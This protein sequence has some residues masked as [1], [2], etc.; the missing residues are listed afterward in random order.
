MG[1]IYIQYSSKKMKFDADEAVAY[2][3]LKYAGDD[4]FHWAYAIPREN[5]VGTEKDR[6][7]NYLLRAVLKA[8]HFEKEDESEQ[9]KND[10]AENFYFYFAKSNALVR[11]IPKDIFD[12]EGNDFFKKIDPDNIELLIPEKDLKLK[13]SSTEDLS[14]DKTKKFPVALFEWDQ[15]NV[16]SF[17]IKNAADKAV[18]KLDVK[19]Q[20][21]TPKSIEEKL[22]NLAG[23]PQLYFPEPEKTTFAFF[24]SGEHG[25]V[26]EVDKNPIAPSGVIANESGTAKPNI[27]NILH[28]RLRLPNTPLR[29]LSYD[30]EKKLQLEVDLIS[31][32]TFSPGGEIP[33]GTLIAHISAPGLSCRFTQSDK[34]PIE[35]FLRPERPCIEVEIQ[36]PM[37]HDFTTTVSPSLPLLEPAQRRIGDAVEQLNNLLRYRFELCL[38]DEDK[39]WEKMWEKLKAPFPNDLLRVLKNLLENFE[40]PLFEFKDPSVSHITQLFERMGQLRLCLREI[41]N[42]KEIELPKLGKIDFDF[43]LPETF[44]LPTLPSLALKEHL[45]TP[46]PDKFNFPV[47]KIFEDHCLPEISCMGWPK[48]SEIKKYDFSSLKIRMRPSVKLGKIESLDSP[49]LRIKLQNPWPKLKLPGMD[50]RTFVRPEVGDFL[51][52]LPPYNDKFEV[53]N[54]RIRGFDINEPS[55]FKLDKPIPPGIDYSKVQVIWWRPR[56]SFV[57]RMK[58]I[59]IKEW[60][61]IELAGPPNLPSLFPKLQ[62]LGWEPPIVD[63]FDDFEIPLTR[64]FLKQLLGELPP[65]QFNL[66]EP[67]IE[68]REIKLPTVKLEKIQPIT[69]PMELNLRFPKPNLDPPDF[70][71]LRLWLGIQIDL[72]TLALADK[73]IYFYFPQVERGGLSIQDT[74]NQGLFT[75]QAV[76]LDFITLSIPMRNRI[77]EPP[78]ERNHDGY[79]EISKRCLVI[80]L[81][82]GDDTPEPLPQLGAYFPGGVSDDAVAL[83]LDGIETAFEE[84]PPEDK[85]R[86]E[87]LRSELLRRFSLTLKSFSPAEWGEQS[88]QENLVLRLCADGITFNG[89]V[90]K[91]KVE[92]DTTGTTGN[93]EQKES[94]QGLIEPFQFDP[95]DKQGNLTSQVVIINN[96]IREAAVCAT[97]TCPG[98]KDLM[99]NIRVSLRQTERGKLPDV[100]ASAELEQSDK[101]PLAQCSIGMLDASL[102]TM[103]FE[104]SWLRSQGDWDYAAIADAT[105]GFSRA[106]SVIPDLKDL[107]KPSIK[108][109][110]LDLRRMNLKTMRVP[111]ALERTVRFNILNNLFGVELGDLEV[112]WDWDGKVPKP[113]ILACKLAKFSYLNPGSLEVHISAGAL[114]ID[115]S[116]QMPAIR[117]PSR[118]GIEVKLSDSAKFSGEVGWVDEKGERYLFASGSV[119]IEGLPET[120]ALLKIGTGE[121]KDGSRHINVVLFGGTEGL[122]T[123]LFTGAVVKGMGTGIGINNR[124]AAIPARPNAGDI[125]P[126]VESIKPGKIDSWS[127]V[128]DSGFYLSVIGSVTLASNQGADTTINAYVAKLIFSLDTNLDLVAAG[129]LWLSTSPKQALAHSDKPAAVG[130]MVLSPRDNKLEVKVESRPD[131]YV[132]DNDLLKKLLSKAKVRFT[133]R[134][135]PG[136]VDYYLEEVSYRDSLFGVDLSIEGSYRFAVFRN[137]VLLR[138]DIAAIGRLEKNLRTGPGG[139]DLLGDVRLAYGYAGLLT[140]KGA[141]AYA[142][143]DASMTFNV[144]AWIEIGFS[145]SFK[146]CGKRFHRSWSLTFK[147]QAPSLELTMRGNIGLVEQGNIGV[148]C[149]VGIDMAI[150]GYRLSGSAR[151]SHQPELYDDARN[152]IGAF[153]QQLDKPVGEAL[154]NNAQNLI[155]QK[156]QISS[157]ARL[158]RS[159]A[160]PVSLQGQQS[161][162]K[163]LHYLRSENSGKTFHLLL[164][165]S[166]EQWLTPRVARIENLRSSFG[167]TTITTTGHG[168]TCEDKGKVIQ[169]LGLRPSLTVS[170]KKKKIKSY[171]DLWR[172]YDVLDCNTFEITGLNRDVELPSCAY[173][174]DF[175]GGTWILHQKRVDEMLTQE[176]P[177]LLGDVQRV[178]VRLSEWCC[179]KVSSAK[180][181]TPSINLV[182]CGN[183]LAELEDKTVVRLILA[184]KN[185]E[186][187]DLGQKAGSNQVTTEDVTAK[188]TK[189]S[190]NTFTIELPVSSKARFAQEPETEIKVALAKEVMT[191]WNPA[192]RFA[193]LK[194]E[195]ITVEDYNELIQDGLSLVES[196]A[197]SNQKDA[198][199]YLPPRS[200]YLVRFSPQYTS[201]DKY[202]EMLDGQSRPD[203]VRT[204]RFRPLQELWGQAETGDIQEA[205]QYQKARD[206]LRHQQMATISD[207]EPGERLNERRAQ[208]AEIFIE[209]FNSPT[210]PHHF[211]ERYSDSEASS[212]SNICL[213][214]GFTLSKENV[215]D[216]YIRRTCGVAKKIERSSPDVVEGAPK[217]SGFV[218][219]LPIRQEFNIEK[220][221]EGAG[222]NEKAR[223][224]VKLPLRFADELLRGD[225]ERIGRLQ[226]F[227][228]I[229][230]HTSVLHR[231]YIRP[232]IGFLEQPEIVF[233]KA[234]EVFPKAEEQN[235]WAQGSGKSHKIVFDAESFNSKSIISV[236]S[237]KGLLC[238]VKG[239]E[240]ESLRMILGSKTI[241]DN[242]IQKIEIELT[243]QL[244]QAGSLEFQIL[245][246]GIIVPSP[247]VF[248]DEFQLLDRKT[249]DKELVE[250]GLEADKLKVHYSA[251]FVPHGDAGGK[252]NLDE[253]RSNG[254]VVDFEPVELFVPQQ[255]PFPKKLA[256]ALPVK[257]LLSPEKNGDEDISFQLLSTDQENPRFAQLGGRQIQENDFEIWVSDYPIEQNGFYV[258]SDPASGAER[259]VDNSSLTFDEVQREPEQ[260]SINS[261]KVRLGV[262]KVN[263]HF[264]IENGKCILKCGFSYRLFI[265]PTGSGS[266]LLTP[267]GKF[268]LRED[269]L[270]EEWDGS[271]RYRAV[272][273]LEQIPLEVVKLIKRGRI[274]PDQETV[275]RGEV[276][277]SDKISVDDFFMGGQNCLRTI[278]QS[279]NL[280]GGGVE[281]QYRD[282]DDS[283]VTAR[284]TCEIFK[285]ERY[286]ELRSDFSTP[287][288]W[289][290]NHLLRK[291]RVSAQP[292]DD[293]QNE[294]PLLKLEP[295]FLRKSGKY[296][297][298]LKEIQK[299]W[300]ELRNYCALPDKE[301]KHLEL[302][303]KTHN[304]VVVIFKYIKSPLNLHQPEVEAAIDSTLMLLRFLIIGLQPPEFKVEEIIDS[305]IKL[306]KTFSDLRKM[307]ID[308]EEEDPNKINTEGGD[309]AFLDLDSAKQLAGIV[310]RR[311]AVADAILPQPST[312]Q[313]VTMLHN[314]SSE[315]EILPRQSNWDDICNEAL[316]FLDSEDQI[317]PR[318]PKIAA[319]KDSISPTKLEAIIT[320]LE[321]TISI[322]LKP[323]ND[324]LARVVPR[325]AALTQLL[326]TFSSEEF[327]NKWSGYKIL[328]RPHHSL[329]SGP[330]ET[331]EIKPQPTPLRN[332][333]PDEIRTVPADQVPPLPSQEFTKLPFQVG[334]ITTF[335]EKGRLRLWTADGGDLGKEQPLRLLQT[336]SCGENGSGMCIGRDGE[337]AYVLTTDKTRFLSWDLLTGKLLNEIHLPLDEKGNSF[338]SFGP[339]CF[340]E[341]SLGL[342]VVL[343]AKDSD[344]VP[345]VLIWNPIQKEDRSQF[346][347][348]ILKTN[349]N[350][351]SIAYEQRS[352]TI[353]AGTSAGR[354]IFWH[355]N[356]KGDQDGS[357]H[358]C[359]VGGVKDITQLLLMRVPGGVRVAALSTEGLV[360]VF[361]LRDSGEITPLSGIENANHL[362]FDAIGLRMAV[363]HSDGKVTI[364][365]WG[366]PL[367]NDPKPNVNLQTGNKVLVSFLRSAEQ[368]FLVTS[369]AC[370]V[371][372]HSIDNENF[373]SSVQTLPHNQEV[374]ALDAAVMSAVSSPGS[375]TVIPLANLW[376]R[377]GFALDIAMV[378][379]KNQLLPPADLQTKVHWAVEKF[380]ECK[381]HDIFQFSPQEHDGDYNNKPVGMSFLKMAVVPKDFHRL[382]NALEPVYLGTIAEVNDEEQTATQVKL[383]IGAP[384][385][386][387]HKGYYLTV[388]QGPGAGQAFKVEAYDNE[389]VVTL[390]GA[391]DPQN[392]K[393][394][395]TIVAL[396]NLTE[397]ELSLRHVG[398]WLIYRGI[399]LPVPELQKLEDHVK[400]ETPEQQRAL[401]LH[402]IELFYLRQAA[403]YIGVPDTNRLG[404]ITRNNG[405]QHQENIL[406]KGMT[407]WHLEPRAERWLQV[408]AV[409]GWIHSL[410]N[411]SDRDGHRTMVAAR[412]VSRYE[413]LVR[414]WKGN[415]APIYIE[416]D[417][418]LF[419]GK[420]QSAAESSITLIEFNELTQ[421]ISSPGPVHL[422][423]ISGK[424]AGQKRRIISIEKSEPDG[425]KVTF[426]ID[427][428]DPWLGD[429]IQEED[430]CRIT[431]PSKVWKPI[432]I[433]PTLN[434]RQ[435]EGDK[436]ITVYTYPNPNRVQYSYQLPAEGQRALYNQISQIRS[437]YRGVD[438]VFRHLLLD[439]LGDLKLSKLLSDMSIES[440]DES[441]EANGDSCSRD[442]QTT[443]SPRLRLHR[444]ERLISIPNLPFYYG[445]RLDVRSLFETRSLERDHLVDA[446]LLPSDENLSPIA[447]RK[448]SRLT[449]RKSQVVAKKECEGGIVFFKFTLQLSINDDHL[450]NDEKNEA[451]APIKISFSDQCDDGKQNERVLEAGKIPDF[452]L[453]YGL[454]YKLSGK[455][456]GLYQEAG[457]L[458]MPWSHEFKPDPE[459]DKSKPYVEVRKGLELFAEDADGE[460]QSVSGKLPISIK[461][462]LG[463][464]P[465]YTVS[466]TVKAEAPF[467]SP[468]NFYLQGFREGQPTKAIQFNLFE[469]PEEEVQS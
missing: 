390:D 78:S 360:A 250:Q 294:P 37:I 253:E 273:Q 141:M 19:V 431:I 196:A 38:P 415:H 325:A 231:D 267:L 414:W 207:Q 152:R 148:D 395:E 176:A 145:I 441:K 314:S 39:L 127:F 80:D 301:I 192:N 11:R 1:S 256:V 185:C 181:S 36:G 119:E 129:K 461:A 443:K 143:L 321:T 408:P 332:L 377:M 319:L 244:R 32:I 222:K 358:A 171:N 201:S 54:F 14:K 73:K 95:K 378:D 214:F 133:F 120:E 7:K 299:Y 92:V 303:E 81:K 52:I 68:F 381:S 417:D 284:Q 318:L 2:P 418:I 344:D 380:G 306:L 79:L 286:R 89:Q 44:S 432:S 449:I 149:L 209:D 23:S 401:V 202:W 124:L 183:K 338:S 423:I 454:F 98:T 393:P 25:D 311:M 451:P 410:R 240:P 455:K 419:E 467:N 323:R 295:F 264:A 71:R 76:D 260:E 433:P 70:P 304:L 373:T 405:Q 27:S 347:T 219:P 167:C 173:R 402:L 56:L 350:L 94:K 20:L 407:S 90:V 366:Q 101:T 134:M 456:N 3:L 329:A 298:Q 339:A 88:D 421:L 139:F 228:R 69:I 243:T 368:T 184:D 84:S 269:N 241:I 340:A 112:E 86:K 246:S 163:W 48:L 160:K 369:S 49:N 59:D 190:G 198:D 427:P 283:S 131:P 254:R 123:P 144:K 83:G 429:A 221:V 409:G 389:K 30:D 383:G 172:L 40:V 182:D 234:E 343:A 227:R 437:G 237:L 292:L 279:N 47:K 268:L 444:H 372:I 41:G 193:A 151:W 72:Q 168:L 58:N 404:N 235:S 320:Q 156:K 391:W 43:R 17:T 188:G 428:G 354:I 249:I 179:A 191:Y 157:L 382:C 33:Q 411:I 261:S 413:Q 74:G 442:L 66:S 210:G 469:C 189:G 110:D 445:Y 379:D 138:S 162:E 440:I 164:P 186:I 113:R 271:V 118:L 334:R 370:T 18:P 322:V 337:H 394:G 153:E 397:S 252:V 266:L 15:E 9:P 200:S 375:R 285:K 177:Q 328:K 307:L 403:R 53:L 300:C 85:S 385:Q 50:M 87:Q 4:N 281:F 132:E 361:G 438:L 46:F 270:P 362:A 309:D 450:T 147:T 247:Y 352:R 155:K 446:E 398:R 67:D 447:E 424:G 6:N 262:K 230:G 146:I 302:I 31:E 21:D 137:S 297:Q 180:D 275:I 357:N 215:E 453:D 364:W 140:T 212:V 245:A 435:G 282:L 100:I 459:K 465:T 51:D 158:C 367:P 63:F 468:E 312:S 204:T 136:L 203:H 392:R 217:L 34:S 97:T 308:I 166:D 464:A 457:W 114:T 452:K 331:G 265:R 436:P 233:P 448:P 24:H 161:K 225:M 206:R 324:I 220:S 22:K 115:L 211:S 28:N 251:R 187:I 96:E 142:Y 412:P 107:K 348:E 111:L 400:V 60:D 462:K 280:L 116:Q 108:I 135:A 376:E 208:L 195:M 316:S 42:L 359:E 55:F 10:E 102:D 463:D 35:I 355:D 290:L 263:N 287:A 117:F 277:A 75:C 194:R 346:K 5:S 466:F 430:Q 205:L 336:F 388:L 99:A 199:S 224:T 365:N 272:E 420:I 333:L 154:L 386:S 305:R 425:K 371:T 13:S 458:R 342:E 422:E 291:E 165:R 103:K 65:V 121:K 288:Y 353:L 218:K 248:S 229:T 64:C 276:L 374:I 327:K 387:N 349:E 293:G 259:A 278:A 296:P 310:R 396:V 82:Y 226:I 460:S 232:D 236:D 122:D 175:F 255:D 345:T 341:T 356:G 326:D 77:T 216:V 29:S 57:R 174:E 313:E 8:L 125:L 197:D 258:G 128:E 223:L 45:K 106:T 416:R 238:S 93:K 150:C 242:D 91:N 434:P 16:V 61:K 351:T 105:L 104:L 406:V 26:F 159:A 213:G 330:D 12:K 274:Q 169:I 426:C 257:D 399:T 239:E 170:E 439:K 384:A 130:A 126:K 315:K 62:K 289:D 109:K 178:V 363:G 317:A 335:D